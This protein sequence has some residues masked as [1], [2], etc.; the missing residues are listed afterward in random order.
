MYEKLKRRLDNYRCPTYGE[1][2]IKALKEKGRLKRK[3]DLNILKRAEKGSNILFNG[4]SFL[5]EEITKALSKL[6]S[7]PCINILNEHIDKDA[8]SMLPSDIVKEK[9]IL[10]IL[11]K[12]KRL[13]IA[14]TNPLNITVIE[15]IPSFKDYNIR[16]VLCQRPELQKVINNYTATSLPERRENVELYQKIGLDKEEE[17]KEGSSQRLLPKIAVKTDEMTAVSMIDSIL[18]NAVRLRATDIHLESQAQGITVRFRIDGMLY[19]Q[20]SIPKHL[21]LASISR[22][23]VISNMDIT[24]SRLPQDGRMSARIEGKERHFRVSCIPTKMGENV[25]L[26]IFQ[27]KSVFTGFD[28]LGLN[29]TDRDLFKSIIAKPHG[30]ILAT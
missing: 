8:V 29:E 1:I 10:P 16:F 11:K 27:E 17:P 26:R 3:E 6:L 9:E 5:Q 20:L 14:L 18:E 28:H 7:I 15:Q 23:K 4:N 24:E 12:G 30:M 13:V 2:A 22:I 21:S 19:E 25:A